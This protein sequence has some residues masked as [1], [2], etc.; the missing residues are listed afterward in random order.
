MQQAGHCFQ[1]QFTKVSFPSK[2]ART[3]H[4]P[5]DARSPGLPVRGLQT[6]KGVSLM[7]S[8][9]D[10]REGPGHS[11]PILLSQVL[12]LPPKPRHLQSSLRQV[13]SRSCARRGWAVGLGGGEP[14]PTG[15][16]HGLSEEHCSPSDNRAHQQWTES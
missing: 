6:P 16:L 15:P 9:G 8:Q 11:P 2:N 1:P 14:S 4:Q 3:R 10:K 13:P 7:T 12:E 5:P